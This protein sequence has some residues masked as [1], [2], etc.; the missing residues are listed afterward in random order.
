MEVNL[1]LRNF[2][3]C[4]SSVFGSELSLLKKCKLKKKCNSNYTNHIWIRR[5]LHN[6]TQLHPISF[7][8]TSCP[9]TYIHPWNLS[10]LLSA[11]ESCPVQTSLLDTAGHWNPLEPLGLSTLLKGTLVVI[12]RC[13]WALAIHFYTQIFF[14]LFQGLKLLISWSQMHN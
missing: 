8:S 4:I 11:T 3:N 9:F 1:K 5:I 6:M 13:P 10:H 14:S 2:K 12:K 7:S